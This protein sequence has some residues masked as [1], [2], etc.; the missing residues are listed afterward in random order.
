MGWFGPQTWSEQAR[1]YDR[2]AKRKEKLKRQRDKQAR[3]RAKGNGKPR[4]QVFGPFYWQ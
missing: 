3:Q 4:R 1:A 2:Q